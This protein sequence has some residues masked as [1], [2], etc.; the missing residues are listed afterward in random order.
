MDIIKLL[1]LAHHPVTILP[2][3]QACNLPSTL[4]GLHW[5]VKPAV[6]FIRRHCSYCLCFLQFISQMSILLPFE[7][8]QCPL[9]GGFSLF[10]HILTFEYILTG[11]SLIPTLAIYI[12]S[13]VVFEW[14]YFIFLEL[15]QVD[16]K[17]RVKGFP[18][19]LL[20]QLPPNQNLSPDWDIC[21]NQ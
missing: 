13:V 10:V 4:V 15:S 20:P 19:Y 6:S 5:W 21:Y 2:A 11:W 14:T 3:T 1:F 12:I 7:W 9:R 17:Q 8:F 18:M 16:S